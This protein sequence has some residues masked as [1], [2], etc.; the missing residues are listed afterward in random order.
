MAATAQREESTK[1]SD[2]D[3][4][5]VEKALADFKWAYQYKRRFLE[6]AEQDMEFALGKQWD[7][8]DVKDLEDAGVL[9][10]TVNEIAPVLQLL[11][12][13]ESQ[14]RADI[15]A[16]PEGAEDS[17][18]ADI[19]TRLL[20]NALTKQAEAEYKIT[21]CFNDGN[22]CGES[23]LEPWLEQTDD[24]IFSNLRIRKSDYYQFVWDPYS[25]EYD[26]SD[27]QFLCKI[28][29][30]LTRDQILMIYPD[31][32]DTIGD[33]G[34]KI[35]TGMLQA[36]KLDAMGAN[37]QAID[38]GDQEK[39]GSGNFSWQ[40]DGVPTYDLLEYYYKK[41][42]DVWYVIDRKLG[43]V[44]Q[45]DSKE[46][47]KAY[48]TAANGDDPQAE[49]TAIAIKKRRPEVWMMAIVG[50]VEDPVADERA[51]SYPSW[52]SW[53][54]IP[55]FA[56]KSTAKLK[57]SNRDLSVQGITR[58]LKD[59]NREKNK[60]R[61]QELRHLNQ[62]SNSGWLTPENA[63][64]NRD[65]VEEFGSMPGVNLEYK[66]DIGLPQRIFPTPLS[67]G[68]AQLAQENSDD[69][70]RASGINA[71][72]L[73]AQEGGTDSGR[74]IALRQKQGLVMVQGL[75]DNLSRSKKILAKFILSQLTE[76]YTVERAMRVCGDAFIKDN[77][78]GPVMGPVIDPKS[79]RP[80]VDPRTGQPA[81]A[82]QIDPT[83]GQPV[84]QVD[85]QAAQ[86]TF[87][88][89]LND[90]DLVM[91]D[92][93]VG[94]VVSQE[95]IQYANFLMLMDMAKQGIPI[96]PDALIDESLLSAA[97]KQKIKSAIERQAAAMA[98]AP[99]AP[100]K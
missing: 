92:V 39:G 20:K 83:T 96:P 74:A 72:L 37:R 47:A 49:K 43:V 79:G 77:F 66:P 13:I 50:G 63:W 69:I 33:N 54:A 85:M 30:D 93:A 17:V 24:L 56:R 5:T 57:E 41:Y 32:E 18:E 23:W 21:E 35:D 70:K 59:L 6:K 65:D 25:R 91:Y 38:Y 88:K 44:K 28:T 53:P 10:I 99:K 46:Q 45:A 55:Y 14:N 98:N 75:F 27:A 84:M 2:K 94:E 95:T 51:W 8:E 89:V 29:F 90:K 7:D 82:P 64:V 80:V 34:G 61:T 52:R 4:M 97:Q 71:D 11:H 76:I 12:G 19:I 87:A 42:V 9:P 78:T 1:R 58:Q 86:Q 48:E 26:L 15:K 31:A 67:Q 81:M 73:A 16:Y 60:R 3:D 62:S 22:I 36:G 100:K 68:H 40:R